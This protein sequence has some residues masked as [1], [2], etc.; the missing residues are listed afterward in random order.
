MPAVVQPEGCRPAPSATCR[1]EFPTDDGIVHAVDDVS[2]DVFDE[3]D[4]RHRRR[5]GL[6]QD[7][8][9]A[10]VLGLLPKTAKITGAIVF[11]GRNRCSGCGEK[12]MQP[13]RGNKIAMVF[14]D[15]LAALNPVHTV[16]DQIAEAIA[17]H[18]RSVERA[19]CEARV[20][21]LL[22]LVGIPNPAQRADQ[23]PHEF[24]GGMRQRAMIAM[25]I[26]NEPDVL[27]A[28]EPT[29]ALDVTIQAQV[30][31]V[32]RAHPG[33]HQLGDHP[34]HPR[35][36]RRRRRR[37]PRAG[38]VRRAGRSSSAPS[39]RSSTSR[40]TRTRVGLLARCRVSTA[41]RRASR[42][43]RITGQ[44]PSL[45]RVPPG[46]A[47]HPRCPFARAADACAS[48]SGPSCHGRRA[49]RPPRRRATSPRTLD[50][51]HGRR[52]DT[53]VEVA[54]RERRS[55]SR[56]DAATDAAARGRAIW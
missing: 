8:H 42:L 38:D 45:I 24:S 1:V 2:F 51:D 10:G 50:G 34:H 35:P 53:V 32:L 7:R 55:R 28:D 41:G 43:H 22:D 19:S 33:P 3:R 13:L 39:T 12:E 26:A 52:P 5:V 4:A 18:A 36:R 6:G 23:Y 9:V 14:Q 40:G 37:R 21:E 54:R 29:T 47:F 15:A 25:A 20:I 46:C 56:P 31:E 30:L 49:H 27:I 44:P 17:V 16:G 11:R 48:P